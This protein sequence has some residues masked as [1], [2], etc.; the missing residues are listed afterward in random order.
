[1]LLGAGTLS[2]SPVDNT[3]PLAKGKLVL[4]FVKYPM[5]LVEPNCVPDLKFTLV[6][7]THG[8]INISLTSSSV[9]YEVVL[10]VIDCEKKKTKH[11]NPRITTFF[12]C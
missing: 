3:T 11:Q 5:L 2:T 8:V 7:L 9:V 6:A 1:V 4:V 10:T 12:I